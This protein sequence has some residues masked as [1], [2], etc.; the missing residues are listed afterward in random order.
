MFGARG[1]PAMILAAAFMLVGGCASYQP[2]RRSASMTD[3]S[4][5]HASY[6]ILGNLVRWIFGRTS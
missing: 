3:C 2:E 1:H 4:R 6:K 5:M